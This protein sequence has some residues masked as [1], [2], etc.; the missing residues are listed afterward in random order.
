MCEECES[1]WPSGTHSPVQ[2]LTNGICLWS[3]IPYLLWSVGCV[4]GV[5]PHMALLW[6]QIPLQFAWQSIPSQTCS[7]GEGKKNHC[8]LSLSLSLSLSLYQQHKLKKNRSWSILEA[9]HPSTGWYLWVSECLQ[10]CVMNCHELFFKKLLCGYFSSFVNMCSIMKWLEAWLENGVATWHSFLWSCHW[11]LH[12]SSS[13]SHLLGLL[14]QPL[15][16]SY[17]LIATHQTWCPLPKFME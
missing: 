9:E 17:T 7:P 12:Q 1:D 11:H 15:T 4:D 10:Y 6:V 3:S 16:P 2:L 8:K 14:Y 5:H 13:L